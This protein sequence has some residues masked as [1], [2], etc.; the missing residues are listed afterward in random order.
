MGLVAYLPQEM[1]VSQERTRMLAIDVSIPNL[2]VTRLEQFRPPQL[3][4]Q[5]ERERER[6]TNVGV[7]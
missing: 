1:Q 5:R 6:P 2:A 3:R 4:N 7:D